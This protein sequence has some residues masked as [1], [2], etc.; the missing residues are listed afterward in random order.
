M[1]DLSGRPGLH[2]AEH[3]LEALHAGSL[4]VGQLIGQPAVETEGLELQPDEAEA[5]VIK[6]DEQTRRSLWTREAVTCDQAGSVKTENAERKSGL[7]IN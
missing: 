1:S 7:Q 5:I 3:V 2:V 6:Q 4:S